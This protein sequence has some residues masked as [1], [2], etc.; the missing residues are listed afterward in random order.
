[1][2]ISTLVLD[3][4]GVILE[5]MDIKTQAFAELARPYGQEAVDRLTMYHVVHGGINRLVKFAWFFEEFLGKKATE[6]DLKEWGKRFEELTL[7]AV[8]VSPLVP[9][10]EDVLKTWAGKMPIYVCSG[11]PQDELSYILTQR[12]LHGYFT[13]IC[14]AP[15]SK[16]PLLESIIRKAKANPAE[17]L[18]VGDTGTDSAAAEACGTLFYGR[19]KLFQNTQ[20][21]WEEDL[22]GL[23][24]WIKQN[25]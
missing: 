20:W 16:T 13:E 9:G 10:I 8:K 2:A 3:C 1:M 18:M 14:G 17:V 6:D 15:P 12:N 22:V 21:P 7:E 11:A 25:K 5:S 24:D 19:G 23:N 4:D